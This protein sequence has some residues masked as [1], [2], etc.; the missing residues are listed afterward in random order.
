MAPVDATQWRL[1]ASFVSAAS[2]KFEEE[3]PGMVAMWKSWSINP[4]VFASRIDQAMANMRET[5]RIVNE[6]QASRNR[7][8]DSVYAGWS[9]AMRG[10]TTLEN[11][12]TGQRGQVG[13]NEAETYLRALNGNG[14]RYREVPAG[15]LV[16]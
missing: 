14:G 8:Q 5:S 12:D 9:E 10:V 3:F 15:E 6:A 13:V 2:D 4:A 11:M 7:T 1:Y 16:R